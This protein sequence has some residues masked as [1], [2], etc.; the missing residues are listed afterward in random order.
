MSTTINVTVD[1]G[2]LP[3]KN[4][5]QTTANRQAF[6]QGRASQQAAQQGVDQRAADRRAA[7]LD[8]TTGRPLASAGASSRM[9]RIDQEPAANRKGDEFFLLRPSGPSTESGVFS[10]IHR[11]LVSTL[12]NP[13]SGN[14]NAPTYVATGGPNN[15]P[16]LVSQTAP[17]S[18]STLQGN[19]DQASGVK[20]GVSAFTLEIFMKMGDAFIANQH[21]V[22]MQAEVGNLGNA[23]I[24]VNYDT[25]G[26]VPY[27]DVQF[28]V[29]PNPAT[30]FTDLVDVLEPLSGTQVPINPGSWH[31]LAMTMTRTATGSR[32]LAFL[33]GEQIGIADVIWDKVEFSSTGQ[34]TELNFGVVQQVINSADPISVHGFRFD[35]KALYTDNFTPPPSL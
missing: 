20:T 29:R 6:V 1:D 18:A 35:T 11:R 32:L 27:R 23:I 13:F 4:R 8:P 9:K 2:G 21:E 24:S 5:Q 16:A 17:F 3:A 28:R 30:S 10:L 25:R 26:G 22:Y 33:D 14:T 31:H 19:I 34:L 15:A 12:F 7:G